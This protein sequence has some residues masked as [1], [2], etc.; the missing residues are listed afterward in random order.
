MQIEK[1]MVYRFQGKRE[2]QTAIAL[3][4][5]DLARFGA[6]TSTRLTDEFAFDLRETCHG[7]ER[8]KYF[9]NLQSRSTRLCRL[10]SVL[11]IGELQ[12]VQAAVRPQFCHQ[13]F[14][15]ANIGNRAA[16][17]YHDSVR[18]AHG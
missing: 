2:R 8:H 4:G 9:P 16:F 6:S 13:I 5:G 15:G 7:A 10:Q 18:A 1:A 14:M 12:I 17:N 3:S 11:E